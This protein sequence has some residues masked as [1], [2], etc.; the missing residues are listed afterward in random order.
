MKNQISNKLSSILDP[1]T[2]LYCEEYYQ[3]RLAEEK[4]RAERSHNPLSLL[5][6]DPQRKAHNNGRSVFELIERIH[7]VTRK[8]DI[9]ACYQEHKIAIL[10]P[11]TPR[12]GALKLVHKLSREMKKI[13]SVTPHQTSDIQWIIY[14][15]GDKSSS[16]LS[17]FSSL[18]DDPVESGYKKMDFLKM[19][20]NPAPQGNVAVLSD[21]YFFD[22]LNNAK[23]SI[24]TQLPKK[25]KRVI[26]IA[27]SL[28][29]IIL[30]L[31]L[32]II[33]CAL[34][35]L[36]SPGPLLF[37]QE[38]MGYL[39]KKFTFLKFRSMQYNAKD[40][41]HRSYVESLMNENSDTENKAWAK[42]HNDPRVTSLGKFMRKTS[43][44]ELPQFFN[45]LTGE[46][47]LV[48]PR[49]PIPYE[50]KKY[51][52]WHWKKVTDVKP[53]I[54]GLWQVEGRGAS[55]FNDTVRY[56]LSYIENWSLWLDLKIILKTFLV[57]F[58]TKGAK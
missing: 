36:T 35:K 10:M 28:T 49:P 20:F 1:E 18:I 21:S 9:K 17:H 24:D 11:Y 51:Q 16:D 14:T 46:M 27:G 15:Y 48:G 13:D 58:S 42:L 39:G 26:D 2:N 6:I 41:L 47:S 37:K 19:D 50:V 22:I 55:T 57:V 31:P 45:V 52:L 29:G 12:H 33:I 25:I 3:L 8:T 34:I 4:S 54:T 56:D 53:G 5:I 32:M 43:I 40:D 7:L 23:Q 30:T 38:R 44:D